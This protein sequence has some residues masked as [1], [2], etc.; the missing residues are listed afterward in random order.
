[1]LYQAFPCNELLAPL[2][3]VLDN[4]LHHHVKQLPILFVDFLEQIQKW[5][6]WSRIILEVLFLYVNGLETYEFKA[7]K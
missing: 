5:K 4:I 6:G 3:H 7:I 1:V 2:V